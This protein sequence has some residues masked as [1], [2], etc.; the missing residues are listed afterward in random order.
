MTA[1]ISARST[2]STRFRRRNRRG[3]Q[4]ATRASTPV[5]PLSPRWQFIR[6]VLVLVCVLSVA[7]LLEFTV[8]SSVQR[9]AAQGRMFDDFRE[10]LALGTAPIGPSGDDGRELALGTPVAF[11]EI[12]A[13]GL[14]QVVSEGTTSG[15]LLDGP[16]HRRDTPLPGQAGT[17]VVFG[18]RAA[19]G[20]PFADIASLRVGDSITVT[21]GQ[22]TWNYKVIS[23]RRE[24]DPVPP[25]VAAGS[26]RLLLVTAAGSAYLPNGLIRV[27]ADLDGQ[28]VGGAP[29]A[30]STAALPQ[31]ERALEGDKRTLWV[32]ALWLQ[33]LLV[34][35]MA[36]LWAWFRWGR[37]QTWIVFT[38]LLI[39]VGLGA[40]GEIARLLPNLL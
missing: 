18:R 9:S 29:R 21:T 20:G 25:P 12:R 32:L 7:M 24:G 37:A 5:P 31:E 15:V 8:V 35:V 19:F 23:V 11:L 3:A 28:A 36:A 4:R 30:I 13:I 22:G 38:P 10:Q 27:D 40:A 26:S 1:S 33:L 16:G 39:L 2:V 6:A 14:T 34:L 17:S